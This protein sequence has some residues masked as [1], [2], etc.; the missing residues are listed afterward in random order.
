MVQTKERLHKANE[1]NRLAIVVHD[2][3]DAAYCARHIAATPGEYVLLTVSDNGCG[4]DQETLARIFEPFFTTKTFGEGTSLG[5][6]TV[7]GAVKQNNGFNDVDSRPGSGTTFS[8]YLPRHKSMVVQ[9]SPEVAAGLAGGEGD[10]PAGRGRG[11]GP[12]NDHQ[13]AA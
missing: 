12:E 6:A 2:A 5:L 3:H 1:L 10:H 4:M 13:D 8:I 11:C 9:V 7:H